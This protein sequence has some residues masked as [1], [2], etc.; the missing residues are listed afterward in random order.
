MTSFEFFRWATLCF[1]TTYVITTSGIFSP[2]RVMLVGRSPFLRSLFYCQAC[3][4]FWVGMFYGLLGLWPFDYGV[5]HWL[6]LREC[7]E[8]GCGAMV[9]GVVWGT[10]YP[11]V[12]WDIEQAPMLEAEA[13]Q[14]AREHEHEGETDNQESDE[15]DSA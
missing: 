8:S 4:G 10:I 3:M 5:D 1:G 6:T 7:A 13:E 14:R 11:N 2:I 15:D 12:A 9:F